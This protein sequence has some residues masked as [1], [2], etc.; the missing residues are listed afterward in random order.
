MK[1]LK[2]VATVFGGL[3]LISALEACFR[4]QNRHSMSQWRRYP[5]N[6]F[7]MKSG[8]QLMKER[9]KMAVPYLA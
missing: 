9:L 7:A 3:T 8:C 5:F 4:C 1:K 2:M 6:T